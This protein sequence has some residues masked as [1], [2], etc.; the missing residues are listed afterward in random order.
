MKWHS[1]IQTGHF[2]VHFAKLGGYRLLRSKVQMF[3]TKRGWDIMWSLS[4]SEESQE[5]D[6]VIDS[7]R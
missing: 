5:E 7:E 6:V 1:R 4:E 2:G 3:V